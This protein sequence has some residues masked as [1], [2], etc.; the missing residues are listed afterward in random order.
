MMDDGQGRKQKFSLGWSAW[1]GQLVIATFTYIAHLIS[2]AAEPCILYYS[3]DLEPAESLKVWGG[4]DAGLMVRLFLSGTSN[5]CQHVFSAGPLVRIF[6]PLSL[7][8]G[9]SH[10]TAWYPLQK[11]CLSVQTG[12]SET[13][14][15]S[16]KFMQQN[17][18]HLLFGMVVFISHSQ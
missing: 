17:D 18:Y 4:E 13:V 1:H 6:H 11:R 2:G 15:I 9:F 14:S 3:R 12:Y 10:Q 7:D 8:S 5:C 16:Q